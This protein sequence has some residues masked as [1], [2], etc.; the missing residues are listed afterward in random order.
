MA[1]NRIE[2]TKEIE[3]ILRLLTEGLE[4][5]SS[6]LNVSQIG[7]SSKFKSSLFISL[8]KVFLPISGPLIMGVA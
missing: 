7:S 4:E 6:F 2:N 8:F 1:I 5:Q 3:K